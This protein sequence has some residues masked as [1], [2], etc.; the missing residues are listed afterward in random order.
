[1]MVRRLAG[2]I[3]HAMEG[4]CGCLGFQLPVMDDFKQDVDLSQSILLLHLY[5]HNISLLNVCIFVVVLAGP[6]T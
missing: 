5:I 6:D 1:M 4:G 3:L 2:V